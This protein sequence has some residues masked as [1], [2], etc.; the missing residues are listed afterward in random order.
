MMKSMNAAATQ[1]FTAAGDTVAI[2]S[3]LARTARTHSGKM[4]AEA[5]MTAVTQMATINKAMS[6]IDKADI[7]AAKRLLTT[8]IFD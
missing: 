5:E 2:I 4:R 6:A 1:V 8:S 3:D 7:E